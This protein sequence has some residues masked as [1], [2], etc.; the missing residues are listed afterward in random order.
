MRAVSV[1][2][3]GIRNRFL[4]TFTPLLL[5]CQD[6]IRAWIGQ[7]Y[8]STA[9]TEAEHILNS[10]DKNEVRKMIYSLTFVL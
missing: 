8:R 9:S 2:S 6:E 1:P 7:V 3:A 5:L 4:S 10:G